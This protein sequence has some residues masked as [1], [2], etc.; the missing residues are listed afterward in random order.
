MSASKPVSGPA[1]HPTIS[2][3]ALSLAQRSSPPQS[4]V[5]L[6]R[7]A[8]GD[9]QISVEVGDTSPA[10][11]AQKAADIFDTLCAK[12][13]RVEPPAPTT[14][15]DD[16]AETARKQRVAGRIAATRGKKA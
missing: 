14:T 6:T 2:D 7:N 13:P 3:V 4:K 5:E 9:V 16:D 11:A 1:K 15:P 8:K 10:L 12:Y